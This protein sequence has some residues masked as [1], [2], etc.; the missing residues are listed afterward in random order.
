MTTRASMPR[1]ESALGKAPRTSPRPPVFENGAH[2]DPT[3]STLSG[4]GMAS[5]LLRCVEAIVHI[6]EDVVLRFEIA[7]PALA[8]LASQQIVVDTVE[9]KDVRVGSALGVRD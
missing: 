9:L 2:S 5:L 7:E 8:H 3:K 1:R 6:G 4:W